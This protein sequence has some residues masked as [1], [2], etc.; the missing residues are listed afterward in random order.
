MSSYYSNI[1][2]SFNDLTGWTIRGVNG[3]PEYSITNTSWNGNA[4]EIYPW[5]DLGVV[6]ASNAFDVY[7]AG[8]YTFSVNTWA[9]QNP[10]YSN[11]RTSYGSSNSLKINGTY[12]DGQGVAAP[13]GD[14]WHFPFS[15]SI[16]LEIGSHEF[17]IELLSAGPFEIDLMKKISLLCS[18]T[19]T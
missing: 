5:S 15:G 12:L 16:E 18:L 11:N 4:L 7:E 6:T 13:V 2:T 19:F 1:N 9:Y 10:Y 8:T 3:T 14:V 17:Q